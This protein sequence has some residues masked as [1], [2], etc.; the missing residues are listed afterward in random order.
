MSLHDDVAEVQ[1]RITAAQRDKARAEGTRDA[2][3]AAADRARDELLHDFGVTTVEQAELLLSGLRDEL[4]QMTA[5]I[6]AKL[7]QIGV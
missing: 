6:S 7:D 1:A 5:E 4:V 2:A 3:Q